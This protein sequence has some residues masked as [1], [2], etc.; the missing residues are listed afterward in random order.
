MKRFFRN[1]I[2]IQL[3]YGQ[4]QVKQQQKKTQK[5]PGRMRPK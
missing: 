1:E 5:Q 2:S 4:Q 3:P